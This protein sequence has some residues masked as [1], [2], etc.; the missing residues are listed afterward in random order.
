M[1]DN[2][3]LNTS[4]DALVIPPVDDQQRRQAALT[5]CHVMANCERDEIRDVLDA[6]GLA[7]LR[8]GTR[9]PKPRRLGR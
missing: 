3:D 5:V 9:V 7:P 1:P 8:P 6:L 4:I 2:L